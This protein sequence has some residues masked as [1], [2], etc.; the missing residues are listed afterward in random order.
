MAQLIV[1]IPD[2]IYEQVLDGIVYTITNRP[3][4]PGVPQPDIA[5]ITKDRKAFAEKWLQAQALNA[6]RQ[7]AI[8]KAR[9]EIDSKFFPTPVTPDGPNI[10]L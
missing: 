7:A 3:P 6:G 5:T 9:K 1:I 2:T 10:Q 4:R 8:D